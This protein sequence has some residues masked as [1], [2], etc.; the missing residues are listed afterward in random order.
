MELGTFFSAVAGDLL[1]QPKQIVE[2]AHDDSEVGSGLHARFARVV[3]DADLADAE[4]LAN[5]APVELRV[6]QRAG[7]FERDRAAPSWGIN[8]EG[9]S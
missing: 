7:R 9:R 6:D 1:P 4:A 8:L 3:V 5:R 2:R